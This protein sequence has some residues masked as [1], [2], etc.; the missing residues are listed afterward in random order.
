MTQGGLEP[1]VHASQRAARIA[2][3]ALLLGA[4]GIAFAPIFVRLSEL[5]PSAT[6][7]YRLF[8]A[9]PLLWLW[10]A[11]ESQMATP[12][13]RPSGQTEILW[14]VLAGLCFTGDL[15]VWHW[16]L[17][18]TSVANATLF[19][20]FAPIFVSAGAWLFFRERI[21]SVFVAGLVLALFG[22][23]LMIGVSFRFGPQHVLGD[24]LGLLTAVFYAGY[25]LC[26]K[27]LRA[28]FGTA[29]IMAWSG[30]VT[31][32]ALLPITLLSGESLVALSLTGWL[33]LIA[34]AWISHT[35][36]QGLIAYALAHLPA[37]FAS[38]ALLLQPAT[39]AI[40]AWIILDESLGLIQGLGGVLVLLGILLARL[41][42]PFTSTTNEYAS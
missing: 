39:A 29:T 28:L 10:M 12:V 41:A 32:A 3:P 22:A 13:R 7:F 37:S 31:C 4:V 25:L 6:A 9:L 5:E 23:A 27:H 36:G 18:F 38:V 17:R 26:V 8:F 34:L 42:T 1:S 35:G 14:L 15:A 2:L 30:V 19:A 20:N 40:L 21:T 33:V 11:L 16:S 24:G